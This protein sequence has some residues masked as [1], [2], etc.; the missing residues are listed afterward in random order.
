MDVTEINRLIDDIRWDKPDDLRQA[1]MHR[2]ASI[3]DNQVSM[4]ITPREKSYWESAA[5]VLNNIGYPRVRQVLPKILAWLQD[6]NWPGAKEV[7]EFLLNIGRPV[8]PYVRE[9]LRGNDEIWQYWVLECLVNHWSID[10]ITEIKDELLMVA[11]KWDLEGINV[12]AIKL[13]AIHKITDTLELTRIYEDKRSTY[14]DLLNELND[15]EK[16]LLEFK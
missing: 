10:L 15:I 12:K 16:Y 1:A 13:L 2:L 9:V 14:R 6:L 11:R 4:L 7:A 8:V 5:M 3:D